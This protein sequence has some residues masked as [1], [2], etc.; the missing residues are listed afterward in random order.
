MVA[1]VYNES[2]LK[3]FFSGLVPRMMGD[4]LS[5]LL[6]SALAYA[7]NNY[8]FE[9]KELQ[10]YTSATMSVS[11]FRL[12]SRFL[13]SFIFSSLRVPSRILFKLYRIAWLCR[14]RT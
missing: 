9:E 13:L 1:Q 5:L 12:E 7:V 3:G 8:I 2:G 10:M 11:A 6:A 4:A 14:A